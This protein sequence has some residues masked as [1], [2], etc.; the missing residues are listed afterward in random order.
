MFPLQEEEEGTKPE[1]GTTRGGCGILPEG[2]DVKK[3]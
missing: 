1:Q 3:G 2:E